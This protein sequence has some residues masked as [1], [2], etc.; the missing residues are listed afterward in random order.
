MPTIPAPSGSVIDCAAAIA[1]TIQIA[2]A[3]APNRPAARSLTKRTGAASTRRRA[4]VL[5]D[6]VFKSFT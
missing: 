6:L 4:F 1:G 2:A 5:L 3:K